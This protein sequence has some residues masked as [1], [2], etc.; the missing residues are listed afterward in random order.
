[1]KLTIKVNVSMRKLHT[2]LLSSF[3][4]QIGCVDINSVLLLKH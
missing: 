3:E 1:M 4:V 2:K